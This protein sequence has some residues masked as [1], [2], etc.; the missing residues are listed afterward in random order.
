MITIEDKPK[1]YDKT[2]ECVNYITLHELVKRL[3]RFFEDDEIERIV[4][5][6]NSSKTWTD[7]QI[8]IIYFK[9]D[10]TYSIVASRNFREI[11]D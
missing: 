8:V 11:L 4:S 5:T 7:G 10:D 6:C 9:E 2:L 1:V 3:D